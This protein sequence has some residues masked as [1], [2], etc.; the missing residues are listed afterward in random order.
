MLS[1]V[2]WSLPVAAVLDTGV[3]TGD[4]VDSGDFKIDQNGVLSFMASPDFEVPADGDTNNDYRVTVQA[5]DGDNDS[6]F[7]VYVEVIDVEET[8]KVTWTA[9]PAGT[10]DDVPVTVALRQFQPGA[11]LSASVTDP[12]ITTGSPVGTADAAGIT[13][14]WYRSSTEIAGAGGTGSISAIYTVTDSDVGMHIRVVATYSDGDGPEESASFTSETPVQ[15]FRLSNSGPEFVAPTVTRRISENSTGN[16]GG[17]ITATDA[18]NGDI[19]TYAIATSNDEVSFRIDAAS[20]QLMVGPDTDLDFET[21]NSY[22]VEVTAYDS[23]GIDTD[24]DAMVTINVFNV[25]EKPEFDGGDDENVTGAII[26]EN[27]TGMALDIAT[28]TATDP[29]SENVTLSLMG[30]DAGLFELAADTLVTGTEANDVRQ[31][32]S[33]KKSPDFEVPGDRNTDN[34]YEVTVRASDGT[35]NA[36]QMVTVKVIDAP[37]VGKVTLSPEDAVVGVELTATLTRLDG[38]VSASDPIADPKW[39]WEKADLVQGQTCDN[40]NLSWANTSDSA[41]ATTYTPVVDD[42]GFCVRAMVSYT[43]QFE[44]TES[45]AESDGTAVQASR[46]NQAPSFR[47]GTSTFRVVAE[48][49]A[50]DDAIGIPVVA[51]DANGPGLTYTLGGSARDLFMVNPVSGQITVKTGAELDH[52]TNASHT[53]TIT[54]DDGSGESNATARITVTIYVTDVDEALT[55]KDRANPTAE[56]ARAVEYPENRYR[57]GGNLHG[58]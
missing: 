7:E 4:V 49:A 18:N 40:T 19:L 53:V 9:N 10:D 2:V 12:D 24:P 50:A 37:E 16:V 20:G 13:W 1:P 30:D 34:V 28:Y 14:K 5:S 54:A 26:D 42:L 58:Q 15:A 8:G 39:Q 52:E 51:T 46:G 55:I 57:L 45:V 33:F 43:Y 17:P 32:L 27:V 29:E 44:T 22:T 3:E 38:S 56:G 48:N 36:D 35:L 25:D 23:F 41:T 6:Y 31:V 47:Q 11:V 21:K